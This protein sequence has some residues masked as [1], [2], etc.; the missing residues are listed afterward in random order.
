MCNRLLVPKVSP[1]ARSV[2]KGAEKLSRTTGKPKEMILMEHRRVAGE[3]P[4][5]D[6]CGGRDIVGVPGLVF[7]GEKKK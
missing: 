2:E 7:E 4:V 3:T 5:V 1:L 6:F